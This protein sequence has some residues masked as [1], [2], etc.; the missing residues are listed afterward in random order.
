MST[1]TLNVQLPRR[2]T[3]RYTGHWLREE[4]ERHSPATLLLKRNNRCVEVTPDLFFTLLRDSGQPFRGIPWEVT[5]PRRGWVVLVPR[6]V[7]TRR[8]Y[9]RTA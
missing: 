2:I 8:R 5:V 4:I 6:S 3:R 7:T 1:P 9:R